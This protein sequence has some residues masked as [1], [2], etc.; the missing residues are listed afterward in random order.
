[1]YPMR[2]ADDFIILVG[3][4]TGP[5]GKDLA[6]EAAVAEKAALAAHLQQELGLKLSETKTLVTPV[7]MPMRFLGHHVQVKWDPGRGKRMSKVLLPKE[8]SRRLRH[9]V[10]DL[11]RNCTRNKSLDNRLRRLNPILRGWGNFYR[12]ANGVG[13][14][15]SRLDHYVWWTIFRWLRKKHPHTGARELKTRC[16]KPRPGLRSWDWGGESTR[17]FRLSSIA[18]NPYLLGWQHPPDFAKHPGEPGA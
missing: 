5:Q 15:F 9:R 18:R 4:P 1:M 7:T 17:S 8:R 6:H 12:H 13:R 10:K 2:Y 16:G 11:F 3:A 14:A